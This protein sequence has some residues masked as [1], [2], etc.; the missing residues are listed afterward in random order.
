[1]LSL[2][3]HFFTVT[4]KFKHS[5]LLLLLLPSRSSS[6]SSIADTT[7]TNL[8]QGHIPSPHLLQIHARI[9][10][11]GAHQDNL[12]A[13]PLIGHSPPPAAVR[14][15]HH[16]HNPNIFPFNAIIR[17]LADQGHVLHAFS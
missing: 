6:S 10:Q 12:L 1:M 3:H 15:F 11:L 7:F 16:L 4:Q 14:V 13:P 5:S 2:S 17:V 8:S 9:F